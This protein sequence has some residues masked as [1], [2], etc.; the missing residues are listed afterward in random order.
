MHNSG[1]HCNF[2]TIKLGDSTYKLILELEIIAIY[3]QNIYSIQY[4]DQEENEFDRLFN[5][6]NDVGYITQFLEDNQEYLNLPIWQQTPNPED[7]ARQV[8]QEATKLEELFDSLYEN[9]LKGRKPDFDNHFSFLEGKYKYFLQWPPMKSYGTYRPSLLRMYAIKM[10]E[11]VYL[12]TGGGIKLADK[13]QNSPD[14]KD[15][16]LQNI[17]KV[18]T[19]LKENGILEAED[20]NE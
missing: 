3:P 16:V 9:V 7:A 5:L 19:F 14:L 4:N 11:N 6:W 10:K 1:N 12:I 8:L 18:R 20:M 2:A 17:D 13:I 15:H